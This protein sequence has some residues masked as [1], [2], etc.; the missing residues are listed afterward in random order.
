MVFD[1]FWCAHG[2]GVMWPL[3]LAAP[4]WRW[5]RIACKYAVNVDVDVATLR[6]FGQF[7]Y[8]PVHWPSKMGL[9]SCA[10]AI[11]HVN[12]RSM[13]MSTSPLCG[14]LANFYTV[15]CT[16]RQKLASRLVPVQYYM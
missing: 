7:L 3:A 14:R 4:G 15:P 9:S 2:V 8:R 10:G 5:C 6:R 11:L 13:W 12:M 16:G 1:D